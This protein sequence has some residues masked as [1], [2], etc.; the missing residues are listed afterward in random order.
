MNVYKN[1]STDLSDTS[2]VKINENE[3]QNNIKLGDILMTT[4]SENIEDSG[5]ISVVTKQP[6]E[7]IYLN[8]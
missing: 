5:M 1:A 2:V 6:E 4:S 7:N 3:K 8:N